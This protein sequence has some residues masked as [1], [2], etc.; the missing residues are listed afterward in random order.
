VFDSSDEGPFASAF[1]YVGAFQ[2]RDKLIGFNRSIA[3]IKL[4]QFKNYK[5]ESFEFVPGKNGCV[6]FGTD[7]ED[8]GAS[9]HIN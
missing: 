5:I 4:Y 3:P 7:D 9:I 2:T 6:V 1:Y 8:F